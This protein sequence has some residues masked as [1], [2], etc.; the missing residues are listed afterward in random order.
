MVCKVIFKW[1]NSH[2]IKGVHPY[3]NFVGLPRFV[4]SF[5]VFIVKRVISVFHCEMIIF[6]LHSLLFKHQV[7][8]LKLINI[9]N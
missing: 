9:N 1:G 2:Y 4:A 5:S 3:T 8:L 6:K 7:I